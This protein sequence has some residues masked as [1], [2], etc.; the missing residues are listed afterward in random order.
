MINI[1][2][3]SLEI[4]EIT[5]KKAKHVNETIRNKLIP[6]LEVGRDFDPSNFTVKLST[7]KDSLNRTQNMFTLNKYAVSALVSYYDLSFACRVV[8]YTKELE[9]E[10]ET[11]QKEVDLMQSIVWEVI[12][13]QSWIGQN[14][15][16]KMA[17]ITHP[18]LFMRYLKENPTFLK[19]VLESNK[20]QERRVG[21]NAS[22][23]CWKFSQDGFKWLLSSRDTA[24]IWVQDQKA[25]RI[26]QAEVF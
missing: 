9:Q 15:A 24:N 8:N 25:L 1:E 2:M 23:R 12:N 11:K 21:K 18:V 5:G 20:L 3:T 7:Y 19:S 14:Q 22:D 4:A 26:K 16:I 10:L 6:A 13:G 17:G